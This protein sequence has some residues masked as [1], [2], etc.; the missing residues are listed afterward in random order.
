MGE[1]VIFTKVPQRGKVKTGLERK[2]PPQAVE[3][4]YTAF[5]R[6]TVEK[7]SEFN[8][9]ISFYP[10]RLFTKIWYMLGEKKFIVQRGSDRGER[11]S[12]LF[13][14]FYKNRIGYVIACGC[15]APL[16]TREIIYD[17]FKKIHEYDVVFGPS[18][19]GGLYLL[20]GQNILPELFK[21]VIW[22]K[23]NTLRR[24]LENAES[25]GLS[26]SLTQELR[27]VDTPEDL[28]AIWDSEKLDKES[29]TYSI[30]RKLPI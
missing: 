23:E 18:Y 26:H 11:M 17:A 27:D 20:G 12:N 30:L 5:V 13:S 25:L 1:L 7:L 3:Q 19:D 4:V 28:K 16:L 29:E 21:D 2:Y 22:K 6:D 10:E 15:D 9:Y 24:I 14:D 8:P